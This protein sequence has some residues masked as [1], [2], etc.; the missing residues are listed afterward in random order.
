MTPH[1]TY[2]ELI[3]S[4]TATRFGIPNVPTNEVRQNMRVLA[5]GLEKVR[6]LLGKPMTITSGFR[7]KELNRKVGGSKSSAHMT[8]FAADFTCWSYGSPLKIVQAIRDAGIQ[9]DQC[10]EEGTWVHI[11]FAPSMRN[12][13]LKAKFTNGKATYTPL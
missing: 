5:E 9:V 6:A 8:G 10:I 1:F 7:S 4:Q 12:Q 3:A 2:D 11:S 13:F